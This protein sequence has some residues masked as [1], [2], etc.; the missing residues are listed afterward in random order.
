M[1][2]YDPAARITAR[3]AL[4]HPFFLMPFDELGQEINENQ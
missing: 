4:R 3:E 2:V 1:L